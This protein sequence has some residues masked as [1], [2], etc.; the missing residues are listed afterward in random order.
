MEGTTDELRAKFLSPE[1]PSNSSKSREEGEL[2][3]SDTDADDDVNGPR[4]LNY[5]PE[6]LPAPST[7]QYNATTAAREEAVSV[8]SL[9]TSAEGV[10]EGVGRC[11]STKNSKSSVDIPS[12]TSGR[13]NY[14]K[15]TERNRAPFV[16]FVIS[17]SDD[18]SSSD[19]EELRQLKSSETRVNPVGVDRSQRLPASLV[20]KPQKIQR[21]TENEARVM[22]RKASL[23]RTFVSSTDKINGVNSMNGRHSMIKLQSRV[24]NS[25]TLNRRLVGGEHGVNQNMHLNTSKLQDLRQQIEIMEK[26][27]KLKSAKQNKEPILGSSKDYDIKDVENGTT[28]KCRAT[29]VDS[30]P[31]ELKE[32]NKKR[33]KLSEPPPTLNSDVRQQKPPVQ[34]VLPS[35][36]TVVENHSQPRNTDLDQQ[37]KETQH[38]M[39]A[40][41]A[42]KKKEDDAQGPISSGN[43][44]NCIKD[45]AAAI[46]NSN[47]CD[48]NA[49]PV[50]PPVSSEQTERIANN[51]A[52]TFSKK[53]SP[54]EFKNSR[55]LSCCHRQTLGKA[56]SSHHRTRDGEVCQVKSAEKSSNPLLNNSHQVSLNNRGIHS[57]FGTV[58]ISQDKNMDMQSLFDIEELQDKELEEAQ[59]HRRQC[60][61]EERNALRAYRNAQRA[62]IEANARCSYLYQKRELYGAHVQSAIMENLGLF[63]S[64][65]LHNCAQAG[66]N[67]PN[68]MSEDNMHQLPSSSQQMQ[69]EFNVHNQQGHL[70]NIQTA[71]NALQIVSDQQA[72]GH[73]F[74][75]NPCSEPDTSMCEH[76]KDDMMADGVCSPCSN[77]NASA[78]EDEEMFS[79]DQ[80]SVHLSRDCQRKE[81]NFG[82]RAMN[83]NDE[84]RR[85]FSLDGSQDSLLL[86]A[87]LRSQLFARLA[88][89]GL[90]KKDQTDNTET[91]MGTGLEHGGAATKAEKSVKN[92]PFSM[93]QSQRSVSGGNG[94]AKSMSE[95]PVHIDN[96]GH[97]ENFSSTYASPT[98]DLV[99][100]CIS[101]EADQSSRSATFSCSIL[102]SAFGHLKVVETISLVALQGR[103]K[104]NHNY[105]ICNGKENSGT[106]AAIQPSILSSNS[107]DETSLNMFAE[108]LGCY[109]CNLAID[110]FW[111]LCMFELRGKCN[112]DECLRQH[113]KDYSSRSM[114]L[115]NFDSTDCLVGLSTDIGNFNG[116]RNTCKYFD[117]APPT[118]LVCLETLKADVHTYGSVLALTGGQCW[119]KCFSTTLVLSSLLPS[120]SSTDEAFLHG[121]EARIEVCGSWNSQSLYFHSKN[122]KMNQLDQHFTDD[123]QA[124][125]MALLHLSQEA[126][127]IKARIEVLKVLVRALEA[128]P[129]ST[130]L[131]VVYLHIYYSSEK[132][133][134]KHDIFHV[135]VEETEG[136]YE[137]WLMY[138]NSR[139]KLE[140]RLVAYDTAILALC[141]H[142]SATESDALHSSACILDLFLQLV[143]CL[144]ISGNVGKAVDK[145]YGLF[146]SAKNSDEPHSLLLSD[147][148]P[149]L[150]LHDKYVIWLCCVYFMVYR[151]LPDVIVQRFECEKELS[152]MQWPSVDL[153][154]N[155]KQQAITLMDMAVDSLG[156]C[157]DRGSLVNESALKASH[158]FA[159]NHVRCIAVL[160]GLECSRNLLENYIKLYPSCLE[161][162]LMSA[163]MR[164]D[165]LDFGNASFL[166]FE[167]ALVNW[168]EEVPGIQCIWNQYAEYA[169]QNGR[170]DF[171]KELM[172]RWFHCVWQVQYQ[173]YVADSMDGDN[174]LTSPNL[175]STLD[176]DTWISN[177]SEIDAVFGLLNLSLHKFVQN[178]LIKA[179]IAIYGALKAASAEDYKHC[180]REHSMFLLATGLKLEDASSDGILNFLKSYMVDPRAFPSQ[181]LSRKFIQRIK[182]PRVRQ[183]VSNIWSG[184]SSDSS[185]VNAVLEVCHG[186]SLLPQ[187]FGKIRDLVDMTESIID[188]LPSNYQLAMSVC[189]LL[190][191]RSNPADLTSAS[192]S[193]WAS[194]LLVNALIRA[195]PVAAEFVWV[196]AAGILLELSEIQSISES[197]HKRALSVY[198]FSIKLWKS[199]LDSSRITGNTSCVIEAAGERGI[200]LE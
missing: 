2:S 152:E 191:R 199:Y 131:W 25:N 99:D 137:L 63:W 22:P 70:S 103:N 130:I 19:A 127:K 107:L 71:N 112:N 84:A 47:L 23:S 87:T 146:P 115:K 168:P 183:L 85:N 38:K 151:K 143:N 56:T 153:T 24:K 79:F 28:R 86:E 106:C 136:S 181:P 40:G 72:D 49:R 69:A 81:Q 145:I 173:Q 54:V 27:L 116:A 171:A 194:S 4:R 162:I 98:A 10:K 193:F 175:A 121:S 190:S 154:V 150:T 142:A 133:M 76:S 77:F 102:G 29:S 65:G 46:I 91:A 179:R 184:L 20:P 48:K 57:C 43:Q 93:V 172:D 3:S 90:S 34:A 51:S 30:V 95:L 80:K 117:L 113:A 89:K 42:Q 128:H 5:I 8:T 61:I 101:A 109:S 64:S 185:L 197:F 36:K 13:P 119:Q 104:K 100:S 159:L 149:C 148:L 123:D 66:Q 118:Y 140:D 58:S 83:M 160:E 165:D 94:G 182:K 186:P 88:T 125:E 11:V 156:S 17:F 135:A 82:G 110:P 6:E 9:N 53:S 68:N 155:E 134:Q 74:T 174:S 170:V 92:V 111:P 105:D 12:I 35:E 7:S 147:I 166:G 67:P 132:S 16:P 144:C 129:S 158:M 120:D 169:L 195:V 75:S 1:N 73:D 189:K 163:R 200:K 177:S 18:D 31:F 198:P 138:I 126:D 50:D 96:E 37:G 124:L 32:S 192:V 176:P 14:Q 59:E 21:T 139:I 55:E 39:H 188:I 161:L 45:V 122:G 108:K 62:L 41:A 44:S 52:K 167:E 178:D 78:D 114:K 33:L 15:S 60:E 187:T 157:I 164:E 97:V 196:E 180:V 26:E 141:R